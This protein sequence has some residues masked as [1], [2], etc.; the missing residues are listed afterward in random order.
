MA[1]K[2]VDDELD[3]DPDDPRSLIEFS[4]TSY[5]VLEREQKVNLKVKRR[6][7]NDVE[8]RFRCLFLARFV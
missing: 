2:I 4:A 1:S 7:P 8:F 3:L 6:G 5:A